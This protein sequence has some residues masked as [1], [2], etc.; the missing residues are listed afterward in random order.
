MGKRS[1][2]TR[3][4]WD[5]IGSTD[6]TTAHHSA[7]AAPV[8]RQAA[9]VLVTR[10]SDVL[11]EEEDDFSLS[12]RIHLQPQ[13]PPPPSPHQYSPHH[14]NTHAHQKLA[15]AAQEREAK[16]A[17]DTRQV[18]DDPKYLLRT[19]HLREESELQE[20]I[21]MLQQQ[22]Q[23][24]VHELA[25]PNA[26]QTTASTA[27]VSYQHTTEHIT[28]YTQRNEV[29]VTRTTQVT[30][31]R[32]SSEAHHG[33][34]AAAQTQMPP[35]SVQV[36]RRTQ[37]PPP[38]QARSGALRPPTPSTSEPTQTVR[39]SKMAPQKPS[40]APSHGHSHSQAPPAAVQ[41][42][43]RVIYAQEPVRN[44]PPTAGARAN[45]SGASGVSTSFLHG[46]TFDHSRTES[47]WAHSSQSWLDSISEIR[48]SLSA[49]SAGDVR[50]P[51]I[52]RSIS[53]AAAPPSPVPAGSR[54]THS[55]YAHASSTSAGVSTGAVAGSRGSSGAGDAG[56]YKEWSKQHAYERFVSGMCGTSS[57]HSVGTSFSDPVVPSVDVPLTACAVLE[58]AQSDMRTLKPF[59]M[60]SNTG[61]EAVLLSTDRHLLYYTVVSRDLPDGTAVK[62]H[63]RMLLT[64]ERPECV[65][66][67]SADEQM[68]QE[69]GEICAAAASGRTNS[70]K[71][72]IIED[73]NA[74]Y[75]D[76][77]RAAAQSRAAAVDGLKY[78]HSYTAASMAVFDA[79]STK[80]L[81]IDAE[82]E[83]AVPVIIARMLRSMHKMLVSAKCRM[84]RQ[85]MY[86]STPIPETNHLRASSAARSSTSQ[87][88][89]SFAVK[90]VTCKCM[91]MSNDPFPDF[92]MHW[93]DGVK[94]LHELQTG[95]VRIQKPQL[96]SGQHISKA[97][98]WS[99][100]LS[101][102]GAD[103]GVDKCGILPEFAPYAL[104]AQ[105][106]LTKC[107][108]ESRTSSCNVPKVCSLD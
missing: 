43:D 48:S 55:H 73:L 14:S 69:V 30:Q 31:A 92:Y 95:R 42:P 10:L 78:H 19:E 98:A 9:P 89:A 74:S 13:T 29:S 32:A 68:K 15:Q 97:L 38:P 41:R 70:A 53:A 65:L 94:L 4:A 26:S 93:D 80:V 79:H 16:P 18:S 51:P 81:Q 24:K 82:K 33:H 52:A 67:G 17:R 6:T 50:S 102:R 58:S 5:E 57:P 87:S 7:A 54:A 2:P 108:S 12:E 76:D 104:A 56:V 106:A 99:G 64:P 90:N 77:G 107:L 40:A 66:Y 105:K 37:S 28:H 59:C 44:A 71:S 63:I 84:P 83:H 25:E 23:R 62:Q 22:S 39:A 85:T 8:S 1:N 75:T 100:V 86:F 36:P 35:T 46:L 88:D 21:R 91:V 11:M 34:P 27:L 3:A 61:R 49:N 101:M 60:S 72:Q 47:S 20:Q 96:G 45:L 103:G